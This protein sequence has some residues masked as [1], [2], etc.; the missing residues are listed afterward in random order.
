[1]IKELQK[2]TGITCL[3]VTHDQSEA[4]ALAHRIVVM[5]GGRIQ[6]I[7]TPDELYQRPSNAFVAGFIGSPPM[8]LLPAN[9]L[10]D[11]IVSEGGL[12]LPVPF[13]GND[14]ESW[15][16]GVRPED[17]EIVTSGEGALAA[18]VAEVEPQGHETLIRAQFG[19]QPIWIRTGPIERPAP[20]SVIHLRIKTA[21]H[22]FGPGGERVEKA[23]N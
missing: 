11:E 9:R 20:G 17:I 19:S 1:M 3:V 14:D 16:I 12:R 23:T 22:L 5:D 10:D 21:L 2:S 8:N 13:D 7:S 15:T 18:I 6:Q 4:M